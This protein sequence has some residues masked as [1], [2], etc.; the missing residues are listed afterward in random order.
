MLGNW[1]AWVLFIKNIQK[2]QR[3]LSIEHKIPLI[4]ANAPFLKM[5]Q[6]YKK[7]FS[8]FTG[9]LYLAPEGNTIVAKIIAPRLKNIIN[10]NR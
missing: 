9:P 2:I 8:Y 4:N 1:D 6:D 10:K 5:N 7:K 3:D